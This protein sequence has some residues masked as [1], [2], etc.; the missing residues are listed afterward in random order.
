MALFSGSVSVVFPQFENQLGGP[1]ADAVT[2]TDNR[3]RRPDHANRNSGSHPRLPHLLLD[4]WHL[5]IV[6]DFLRCA[7]NLR[8]SLDTTV[9][10]KNFGTVSGGNLLTA[11][12]CRA[13]HIY[14]LTLLDRAGAEPSS[15]QLEL[16]MNSTHL[17]IL[18]SRLAS[19]GRTI[20]QLNSPY[21]AATP[22]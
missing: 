2:S 4:C 10:H 20:C 14:T 21:P 1:R 13:S 3:Q 15:A 19:L 8:L 22:K 9:E 17:A 11:L 5:L 12:R 7:C 6:S 16:A 18:P